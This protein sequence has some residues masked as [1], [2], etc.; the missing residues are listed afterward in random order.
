MDGS[1]REK[2]EKFKLPIALS[3]LGLVLI[4]GG[5]FTSGINKQKAKNYPKESFVQSNK[6]ISVDVSGAVVNA[7]VYKL[8]DGSRVEEAILAAGGFSETANGEYISKYLNMAQ[9]VSDGTKI[10]VPFSGET[11]NTQGSG[12]VSGASTQAKININRATQTQLESLPGIASVRA[13]NII[14]GRPYQNIEELVSRK[15]IGPSIFEN[16]KDQIVVY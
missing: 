16:I 14:S 9:L 2:L 1:F 6:T 5:V 7:G 10:Y 8:Q 3:L 11:V 4:I 15:I 13:S 12:I